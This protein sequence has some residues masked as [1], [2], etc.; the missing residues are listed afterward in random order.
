MKKIVTIL[1]VI[2]LILA[3]IGCTLCFNE[4]QNSEGRLY[5]IITLWVINYLFLLHSNKY[6]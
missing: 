1:A 2:Q 5:L 6:N 3:I 4:G